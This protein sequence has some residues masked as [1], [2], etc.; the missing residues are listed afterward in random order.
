MEI[1]DRALKNTDVQQIVGINK[2]QANRFLL[3]YG[4]PTGAGR[5]RA[6]RQSELRLMQLD[7]RMADFVK[8]CRE[9]L[10]GRHGKAGSML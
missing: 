10:G 8:S 7:G 1:F 2:R 4:K 5:D 6:I 9:N 3:I